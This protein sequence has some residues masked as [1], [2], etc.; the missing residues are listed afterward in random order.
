MDAHSSNK[1]KAEA[2]QED[3]ECMRK[4][5]ESL[6]FMLEVM[7][8]KCNTIESHLRQRNLEYMGIDLNH[9]FEANKRARTSINEF[10]LA[11]NKSQTSQFLVRTNSKDSTLVVK[12]GYQWRKYGQKVTKDNPSP[13]AYFRCSMAPGCPVKKKVQRSKDDKSVLIA[14]YEGQHNHDSHDSHAHFSP[15]I[16]T[17]AKGAEHINFVPAESTPTFTPSPQPITLDLT[18]SGSNNQENSSG[19]LDGNSVSDRGFNG[20]YNKIEDF[21]ASLTKDK[22]FTVSLAAAVARCVTN[23]PKP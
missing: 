23:Q 2:L 14:T 16:N 21:V 22:N 7:T 4:E 13:R 9:Q 5:N 18:L 15:S 19:G 3:L 1:E 8:R 20:K 17:S 6:R 12:D 11:T 10:S